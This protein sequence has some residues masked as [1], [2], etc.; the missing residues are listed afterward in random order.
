MNYLSTIGGIIGSGLIIISYFYS[1]M[2]SRNA[3]VLAMGASTMLNR[4]STLV[5]VGYGEELDNDLQTDEVRGKPSGYTDLGTSYT[6]SETWAK[7]NLEPVTLICK[8]QYKK[9]I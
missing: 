2:I 1:D 3:G 8:I 4:V 5:N 9:N 6:D 7:P